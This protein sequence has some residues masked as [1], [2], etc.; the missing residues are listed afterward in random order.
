MNDN[1]WPYLSLFDKQGNVVHH[2]TGLQPLREHLELLST[3]FVG[4]I[5]DNILAKGGHIE[6]VNLHG[7]SIS[8]KADSLVSCTVASQNGAVMDCNRQRKWPLLPLI[9]RLGISQLNILFPT[10][11]KMVTARQALQ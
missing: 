9:S 2:L 4:H 5:K 7:S 1:C 8:S 3:D 11:T 6:F 10:S